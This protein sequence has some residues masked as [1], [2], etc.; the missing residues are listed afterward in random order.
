MRYSEHFVNNGD[1]MLAAA[2]ATG[3]EGILA[4]NAASTY[5]A[6]R[7][8]DWL[9]IKIVTQQEFIICGYTAGEREYFASLVLGLYEKG[10]LIYVGNVGTGFDQNMLEQ[11]Y[12]RIEPLTTTP[13]PFAEIP[14]IGREITW[15]RPEVVC[16]VKYASWTEDGR[17]RYDFQLQN[18]TDK[19]FFVRVKA[20]FFDDA[21][22]TVQDTDPVR[23]P[24]NQFEIKNITV[25]CPNNQG[26]KV[27]VQVSPAN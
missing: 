6:K 14:Q 10:K 3:L 11:I 25:V 19:D 7:S 26:K 15:V 23:Y 16:E 2:R 4:K 9:K 17:L 5:Q 18:K 1:E 20:T 12:R 21:G 8:R 27:K 24:L 22:V 13:P